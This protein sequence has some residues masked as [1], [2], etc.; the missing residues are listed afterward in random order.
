MTIPI[1]LLSANSSNELIDGFSLGVVSDEVTI[2]VYELTKTV[3]HKTQTPARIRNELR[4]KASLP[5][6]YY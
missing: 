4:L 1:S 5:P 6:K 3:A 2:P